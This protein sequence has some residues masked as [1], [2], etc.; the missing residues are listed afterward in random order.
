MQRSYSPSPAGSVVLLLTVSIFAVA[1]RGGPARGQGCACSCRAST[2]DPEAL[3]ADGRL[4]AF[5]SGE[6][7]LVPGDA[8]PDRNVFVLD[9]RTGQLVRASVETGGH[10]ADAPALSADGRFVAFDCVTDTAADGGYGHTSQVLVRDL[11]GRRTERVSISPSGEEGN[12]PSGAP[13]QSP[14][15]DT[16]LRA[17]ER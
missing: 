4:V 11:Q 5:S 10:L 3:S 8:G 1:L 16:A 14:I 17:R 12:K 6:P 2:V 9:L 7:Y 15:S 13:E